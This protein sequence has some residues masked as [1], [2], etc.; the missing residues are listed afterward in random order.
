MILGIDTNGLVTTQW[1][2]GSRFWLGTRL[3]P[4]Q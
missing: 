4:S 1:V 3:I 2:T